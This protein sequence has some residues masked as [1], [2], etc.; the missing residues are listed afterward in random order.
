[1]YAAVELDIALNAALKKHETELREMESR[2][3]EQQELSKQQSLGRL[4]SFPL[5]E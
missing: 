2:K 5:I 1:V 4:M 3:Q